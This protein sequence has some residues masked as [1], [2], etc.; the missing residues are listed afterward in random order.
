MEKREEVG[1]RAISYPPY[2]FSMNLFDL[3]RASN[4]NNKR[5][6]SFENAGQSLLIHLSVQKQQSRC[7]IVSVCSGQF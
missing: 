1:F 5:N 2:I 7:V 3:S 6:V 4:M